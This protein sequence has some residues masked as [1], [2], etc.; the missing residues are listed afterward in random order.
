MDG[1]LIDELRPGLIKMI[2]NKTISSAM[3]HAYS[4]LCQSTISGL[5]C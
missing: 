3:G 4:V 5:L 1:G 2:I